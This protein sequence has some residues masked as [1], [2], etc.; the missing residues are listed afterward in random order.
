MCN[1]HARD[2]AVEWYAIA[3]TT[4]VASDDRGERM[5]IV[6]TSDLHGDLPEL[7]PADVAIIG[8]DVC[9]DGSLDF[10]Y[11]WLHDKFHPWLRSL[12]VKHVVGI[13][14]NHDFIFEH[15]ARI[16]T[17]YLPWRYLRDSLVVIEGIRFYG[18]PWVPN[19]KRWAF[20]AP[21]DDL[22]S[23]YNDVPETTD[24]VISHGPPR[25]YCDFTV[26]MY[27]S[28]HAGFKEANNMLERVK[29]KLFICGHIHEGYGVAEHP[30]GA[31]VLNVSH[32]TEEYQPI[33]QPMEIDL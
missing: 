11:E 5:R 23:R 24:I 8:G 29:P 22:R 7:P 3:S 2:A 1:Q 31:V 18:M 27:G 20:Y 9:P 19:L 21:D 14:G 33:N 6:A 12:P 15:R 13:A 4:Q 17:L 32:N 28:M 25:G 26:P 10:Q 30:S 16:A